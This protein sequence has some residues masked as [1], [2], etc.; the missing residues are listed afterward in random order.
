MSQCCQ[1]WLKAQLRAQPSPA[2]NLLGRR[3]LVVFTAQ[4]QQLRLGGLQRW[5]DEEEGELWG[6]G[7]TLH[8]QHPLSQPH[9][10][11]GAL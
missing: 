11:R 7:L 9:Y 10:L 2:G 6:G 3:F 4:L 8:G 5:Q 1:K